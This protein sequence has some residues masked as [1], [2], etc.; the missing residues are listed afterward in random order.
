MAIQMYA[1]HTMREYSAGNQT[2]MLAASTGGAGSFY[3]VQEMYVSRANYLGGVN[4]DKPTG[5]FQIEI[6]QT[7]SSTWYPMYVFAWN[8]SNVEGMQGLDGFSQG[9]TGTA[10]EMGYARCVINK[11]NPLYLADGAAIRGNYDGSGN[12]RISLSI[13]FL[14]IASFTTM[15]V[16]G[17]WT[18]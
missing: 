5:K 3:I 7:S 4:Q 9:G 17:Q 2:T 11:D 8:S 1:R 16:N 6:R 14:E 10:T 13:N 18:I 15:S 12:G